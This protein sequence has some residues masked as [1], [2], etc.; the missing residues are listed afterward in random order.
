MCC[1]VC[2]FSEFLLCSLSCA[3]RPVFVCLF[4]KFHFCCVLC[5]PPYIP[6]VPEP[7]KEMTGEVTASAE[8]SVKKHSRLATTHAD[9]AQL[10]RQTATP[11]YPCASLLASSG[12]QSN[13]GACT[14]KIHANSPTACLPPS[15]ACHH[16][17]ACCL[18]HLSRAPLFNKQ[19]LLCFGG[20]RQS[21]S[22][23]NPRN[24]T[25][26]Q[27]PHLY[28]PSNFEPAQTTKPGYVTKAGFLPQR[29]KE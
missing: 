3:M 25:T 24:T 29:K 22:Q 13:S 16:M 6:C 18:C 15:A 21:I 23:R 10:V 28:G 4:V 2:F 19:D 14:Q 11:C 12:V 7:H 8:R 1:V 9:A 20:G 17:H 5:V 27:D 26:T